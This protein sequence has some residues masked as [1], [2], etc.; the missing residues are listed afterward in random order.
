[1]FQENRAPM[2][3]D[4]STMSL[5]EAVLRALYELPA[6]AR[7]CFDAALRERPDATEPE[8]RQLLAD[9]QEGRRV[10]LSVRA[11]SVRYQLTAAGSERLA[12]LVEQRE[13]AVEAVRA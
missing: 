2:R 3:S 8:V 13:D 11:E 5:E 1:M 10:A 4:L 12:T 6:S 7:G 9:L